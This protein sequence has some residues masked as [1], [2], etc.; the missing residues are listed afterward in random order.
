MYWITKI[1]IIIGITFLITVILS[2]SEDNNTGVSSGTNYKIYDCGANPVWSASGDYIVFEGSIGAEGGICSIDPEGNNP[3]I[4]LNYKDFGGLKPIDFSNDNNLILHS[5]SN[6]TARIYYLPPNGKEPVFITN[7]WGIAIYGNIDDYYNIA[8]YSIVDTKSGSRTAMYLTDVHNSK[9]KCIKN[10]YVYYPDISPDGNR[11]AYFRGEGNS[12]NIYVY[13]IETKEEKFICEVSYGP[14][15]LKWSPDGKW[16]AFNGSYTLDGKNYSKRVVW[17][18]SSEGGETIRLFDDPNY[19]SVAYP[20]V[21]HF[22]WSPD[23]KWIV[24]DDN[25]NEIWKVRVFE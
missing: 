12:I 14:T 6:D 23:G 21:L 2:C 4:L 7:G 16:I 10:E 11:L 3:K 9:P 1:K 5:S 13:D 15:C 24:Y 20:G 22:S 25:D 18:V 19:P 8:Y 17:I